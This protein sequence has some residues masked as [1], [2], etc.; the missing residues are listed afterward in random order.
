MDKLFFLKVIGAAA[1]YA[2]CPL[3][4]PLVAASNFAEYAKKRSRKRK[5]KIFVRLF[6]R[7]LAK[8]RIEEKTIGRVPDGPNFDPKLLR[9]LD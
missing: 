1:L 9:F 3:L 6:V 5:G 2:V 8:H 4:V 7:S